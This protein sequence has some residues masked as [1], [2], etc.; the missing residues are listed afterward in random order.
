MSQEQPKTEQEPKNAPEA[1]K[2]EALDLPLE[3]NDYIDSVFKNKIG[4][5]K[6][7]NNNRTCELSFFLTKLLTV[8]TGQKIR[9]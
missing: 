5:T 8:A 4:P 3:V 7:P 9:P 6:A 1:R 2:L